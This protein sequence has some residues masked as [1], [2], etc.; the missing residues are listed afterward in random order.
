MDN[1]KIPIVKFKISILKFLFLEKEVTEMR[2]GKKTFMVKK[3]MGMERLICLFSKFSCLYHFVY[4][5]QIQPQINQTKSHT[6]EL[7]CKEVVKR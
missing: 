7:L 2:G 3:C 6:Y 5:Y 1:F 4:L